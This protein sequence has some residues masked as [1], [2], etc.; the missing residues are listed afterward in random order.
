MFGFLITSVTTNRQEVC[1]VYHYVLNDHTYIQVTSYSGN[2]FL[3]WNTA[4]KIFT[5]YELN[6]IFTE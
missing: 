5:T 2:T 1:S 6:Y 3:W 4:C